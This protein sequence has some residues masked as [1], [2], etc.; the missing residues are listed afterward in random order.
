MNEGATTNN[1]IASIILILILFSLLYG[2]DYRYK[3][4]CVCLYKYF[5]ITGRGCI[6]ILQYVFALRDLFIERSGL[7][8]SM[9][10]EHAMVRYML[11]VN[12]QTNV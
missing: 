12:V 1:A 7:F 2:C 3:A 8:Y 6:E 11:G 10:Y 5:S 4:L 9:L